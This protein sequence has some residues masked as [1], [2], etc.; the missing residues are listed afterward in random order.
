MLHVRLFGGTHILDGTHVLGPGDFGGRKPQR[1]LEALAL[2][3]GQQVSKDRLVDILW[4]D[5]PPP[6]HMST[7]ESYVS[8]LRRRLQPGT[9]ARRSVIRTL[10]RAYLLD[11]DTTSTDLDLFDDLVAEAGSRPT[12]DAHRLL[13]HASALASTDLL[14]SSDDTWW[15][16]PIRADY[17][18]RAVRAAVRAGELALPLDVDA[19]LRLAGR[20]LEL[21]VLCEPAWQLMI[22]AHAATGHRNEALRA[23]RSCRR[24][25]ARELGIR[26]SPQTMAVLAEV[27][28]GTHQSAD[29]RA[30]DLGAVMDATLTLFEHHR[31][32]E[33]TIGLDDAVRVV[34][35]LLPSGELRSRSIA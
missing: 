29:P 9:P 23:Y 1:I 32:G 4:A 14:D 21:D 20:A 10:P 28:T 6:D 15:A 24:L 13:D 34:S 19:A 5:S 12:R 27:I 8:L 31:V 25:L 18:Q 17:R 7:L 11:P 30:D 16:E 3:R 33:T 35:A 22:R 2:H 26:P